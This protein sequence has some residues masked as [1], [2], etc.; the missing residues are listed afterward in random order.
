MR[1]T[2][3]GLAV[4]LALAM[5]LACAPEGPVDVTVTR[6]AATVTV[7]PKAQATPIAVAPAP[8]KPVAA[9]QPAGKTTVARPYYEGKGLEIII[10]SG[11]GG[12]TDATARAVAMFLPKYIPGNPRVIV[13]NHPGAAGVLAAN[14]FAARA[15]PDGLTLLHGPQGLI[16]T[17]LRSRDIVQFDLLK[18]R[19][20]WSVAEGG[21][22]IGIR[23]EAL[24]RLEDPRSQPAVMGVQEATGSGNVVLLYG[25][26]FLG[27]N[28]R[29]LVGFGGSGEIILALRRGEV[30]MISQG[31]VINPL[32][33]EGVVVP[34]AQSGNYKDGK[35]VRRPDFAQ[36]PTIVEKLGDKVPTGTPWQALVANSASFSID[37]WT[38]APPGTPDEIV[39]I[40]SDAYARMS[41][42]PAFQGLLRKT[43]S[44]RFTISTGK[45]VDALMESMLGVSPEVAGYTETLLRK[46][47]VIK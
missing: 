15:K 4:G 20:I 1:N 19:G 10:A 32:L 31:G 39:N 34:L 7:V 42:D 41:S 43:Y 27:W 6:P 17:Q 30:D 8:T 18:M 36:V 44:E 14:S 24:R 22:I 37:K 13:R 40:L 26:E 5:L 9:P 28:V 47:G 33:E 46:F 12:G 21:T 3:F 35:I 16:N 25:R 38:V 29:W 11:P 23:P 45:E 2:V